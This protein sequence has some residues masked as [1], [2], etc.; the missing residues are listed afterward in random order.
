[1]CEYT[2]SQQRVLLLRAESGYCEGKM[3]VKVSDQRQE[4][5]ACF[6]DQKFHLS[7]RW[8]ELRISQKYS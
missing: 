6:L 2:G 3:H 5:S 7:G 1:M 8:Q 4:L